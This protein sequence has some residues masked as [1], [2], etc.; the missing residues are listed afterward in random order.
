MFFNAYPLAQQ[1]ARCT[2]WAGAAAAVALL[3]ACSALPQKPAPVAR[4]DFGPTQS[5]VEAQVPAGTTPLVLAN[6]RG[7]GVADNS[8]SI[9]YR[10]A[11][12]DLRELRPY[13]QARWTVPAVQLIQLRVRDVLS[14][15][16]AVLLD[17]DSVTPLAT[18]AGFP[19]ILRLEVEEFSQVFDSAQTSQGVLR[20]RATLSEVTPK[21]EK[22][23]AQQVF[24]AQQPAASAD[25]AGGAAAMAGV[26]D[27]VAQQ[28]NTWLRQQGR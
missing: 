15:Q 23:L 28:L 18:K 19:A 2:R 4:Y 24:A 22:W 21:G 8:A 14:A 17:D 27:Q 1:M 3:A 12:A 13:T 9:H 6:V 10:L 20:M 26:T 25:A 11:Y 5:P 16:R 7:R